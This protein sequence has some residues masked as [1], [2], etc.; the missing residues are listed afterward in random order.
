MT[1]PLSPPGARISF[2]M[3][4]S[5]DGYIAGPEG[6]H[7]LPTPNEELHAYWNEF[8]R[9][10]ATS[11]Y[12]RR[13]YEVMRYWDTALDNPDST[14]VER[15]FATA[16]Q[17]TPKLVVSTTLDEVGPNARLVRKPD[18]DTLRATIETLRREVDGPIDVS[19]ATMAQSLA[20]LG[21]LDEYRLYL[22]PVVVG[23]GTPFFAAGQ[24]HELEFLGMEKLPQDVVLLRYRP[25]SVR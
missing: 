13:M 2:G 25:R 14:P 16:W 17:T 20:R 15:D 19:G 1:N 21:L 7:A 8:Q 4:L 10:S 5:L 12:G 23:G 6:G 18:D 24:A 11:I 3:M 9:R 22:V